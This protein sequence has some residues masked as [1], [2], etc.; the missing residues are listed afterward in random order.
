MCP[1]PTQDT[2][3]RHHPCP[4]HLRLNLL[5]A[6]QR[7]GLR[8]N[9][10][11]NLCVT[12]LSRISG[13]LTICVSVAI[14]FPICIIFLWNTPPA[15]C[16]LSVECYYRFRLIKNNSRIKASVCL[17]HIVFALSRTLGKSKKVCFR[18]LHV[19][20]LEYIEPE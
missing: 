3:P 12:N 4:S 13:S 10:P 8:W 5:A 18:I 19:F 14:Y 6:L 9:T 15:S 2:Q 16:L 20:K 7:D 17:Y 1:S 11:R